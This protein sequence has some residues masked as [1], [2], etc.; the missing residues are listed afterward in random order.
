[1]I[2]LHLSN[3]L[4]KSTQKLKVEI[5]MLTIDSK[6]LDI[7]TSLN[8]VNQTHANL[9]WSHM[10]QE[11]KHHVLLKNSVLMPQATILLCYSHRL[12]EHGMIANTQDHFM[13]LNMV[14]NPFSLN[15]WYN[16]WPKLMMEITSKIHPSQIVKTSRLI[17]T[18]TLVKIIKV[19]KARQI[20]MN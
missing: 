19:I 6:T 20:K 9:W 13:I 7:F 12:K 14:F 18:K 1:L 5:S 8:T 16:M 4:C 15:T 17:W 3:Q 11:D 10:V 2:R